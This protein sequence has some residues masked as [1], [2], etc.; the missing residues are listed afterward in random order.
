MARIII[1]GAGIGG[2]S[3][4]YEMKE[5]SRSEDEVIVISDSDTF[6]FVPSNPWVAVKWR[7][8]EDIKIELAPYLNKKGIEFIHSAL[9]SIHPEEN[10]LL[11]KN[12][13]GNTLCR[14]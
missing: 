14:K 12:T 11:G 4:A 3:M 10:R 8:P 2:V 6:H 5:L 1:V 9:T 13:A 7:K